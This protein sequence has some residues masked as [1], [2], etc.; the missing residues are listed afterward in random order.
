MNNKKAW[1]SLAL[2]LMP[3]IKLALQLWGI[4]IPHIDDLAI[5]LAGSAGAA[6]LA[7]SPSISKPSA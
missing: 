7:N 1:V 2:A 4:T 3:V 6:G 5:A